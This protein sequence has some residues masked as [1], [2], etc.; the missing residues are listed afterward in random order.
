MIMPQRVLNLLI[1]L[2]QF[3]FCVVCL[4]GSSPD[5]T[6]SAAAWRLETQGRWQG[7]VFRPFIDAL[8]WPVQNDHCMQAFYSEKWR[9]H[10]PEDDEK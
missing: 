2:D 10:L 3:L 5:E 6:A 4:G 9:M 8:F 1:A 7:K